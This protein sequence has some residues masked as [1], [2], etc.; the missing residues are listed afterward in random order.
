M[1]QYGSHLRY[2]ARINNILLGMPFGNNLVVNSISKCFF[3]THK[4]CHIKFDPV[5]DPNKDMMLGIE[6]IN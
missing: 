5:F 1:L 6:R 3:P 4:M 2:W